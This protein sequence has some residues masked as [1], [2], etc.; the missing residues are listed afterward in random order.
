M[1]IIIMG[2]TGTGKSTLGNILSL[3][4]DYKL[5][6]IGHVVK[7]MYLKKMKDDANL[8]YRNT[9]SSLKSV[10]DTFRKNGKDFFTNKRLEYV[11]KM[12]KEHGNNYFVKKLLEMNP[13]DNIIIV[14]ARSFEEIA[15][16]KEKMKTPFFVGLKCNE[17][18]LIKRFVA[19]EYDFM[20]PDKAEKIFEKRRW[21][22]NQWGVDK[23]LYK[24]NI[25]IDTDDKKP[26]E[27]ASIVLNE[28]RKY[29]NE[30]NN[31]KERIIYERKKIIC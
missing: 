10:Q 12:V 21:T 30:Q 27:I 26:S 1:G 4:T 24:C 23:V 13:S 2:G 5:Y 19:R 6:E 17:S 20:Q 3:R 9:S 28:Y 8:I 18:R 7:G 29:I 25:V 15:V 22:E 11:N 14:G 31:L 16:I